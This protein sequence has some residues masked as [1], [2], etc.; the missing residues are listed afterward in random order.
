MSP[1]LHMETEQ[2]RNVA[3]D[4]RRVSQSIIDSTTTVR[5]SVTGLDWSGNSR[6][7]FV[8]EIERLFHSLLALGEA[9]LTLS[10]RVEMEVD[11]WENVDRRFGSGSAI[12][13]GSTNT[14]QTPL[15]KDEIADQRHQA[16]NEKWK[17]MSREERLKF[18]KSILDR[19][20]AQYGFHSVEITTDNMAAGG[21][22]RDHSLFDE[23]ITG[24]LGYI[25]IDDQVLNSNNIESSLSNLAHEA[26][27]SMQQYY[28][29]YPDRAPSNISQEQIAAWRDSA[30]VDP[31]Q[32]YDGYYNS[33]I[34]VDSRAFSSEFMDSV[35]KDGYRYYIEG[36]SGGWSG[37]GGFDGGFSGGGTG[38]GSG[39]AW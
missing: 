14:P 17:T 22:Y 5:S 19:L 6:D 39:G 27:H 2:T 10:K 31:R 28:V 1:I 12:P 13:V 32:D 37:S 33:T 35:F 34:E 24:D 3:M 26:R 15:S 9:G 36:Q 16:L 23:W 11:E 30:H 38:G 25:A 18:L 21:E 8:S 4:Y 7:E 29:R 20:A